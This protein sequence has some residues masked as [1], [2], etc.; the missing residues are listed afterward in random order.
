MLDLK[1]IKFNNLRLLV[2]L[3][4]DLKVIKFNNLL[5]ILVGLVLDLKV[6]TFDFGWLSAGF[7]NLLD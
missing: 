4:L 5:Y 1:V 7:N 2:G 3:V 6:I